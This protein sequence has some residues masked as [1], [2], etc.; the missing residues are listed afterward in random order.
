MLDEALRSSTVAWWEWDIEKNAVTFNDLKVTMLGYRAEDFAGVG[1]QAFTDLLHPEDY[2]R[3]M[4]AMRAYLEGRAHLYEIDYRI[5]R[6]DGVYTW[7]MD[8]G[9]ATACRAD[10]YPKVLRGLVIDLG[11]AFSEAGKE[12]AL[13]EMFRRSMVSPSRDVGTVITICATCRKIKLSNEW[14]RV[15][16]AFIDAFPLS[17]SHGICEPCIRRLYPGMAQHIVDAQNDR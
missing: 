15:E 11:A 13:V 2:E 17:L 16:Q 6:A 12:E 1:Y 7:Y 4:E 3:T 10:G 8:R 14:V 5:R 9:C